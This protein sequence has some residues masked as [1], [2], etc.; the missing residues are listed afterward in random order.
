MPRDD[1]RIRAELPDEE[2]A[3]GFLGRLHRGPGTHAEELVRELEGHR[4][5]V[6]RDEG[7]VFVYAD[8]PAAAE[9]ALQIIRGELAEEGMDGVEPRLEH[10]LDEEDRWDDEPAGQTWEQE[11]VSRG[12]APWEVRIERESRAEAQEL[13][14]RLQGGGYAVA[15]SFNYVVVGAES[16]EQARELAAK[17][18]GEVEAG[19]EA[20][21]E[22]VPG[23][24]FAIF[25]G[26]GS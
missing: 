6:S 1:W 13:G 23:N 5:A 21:W 15:R 12:F 11:E 22:T 8:S 4:L 3:H 16:K 25:G 9:S 7:T 17:L 2:G 26:L 20:V 10:W 24:P 19:G 14:D 18:G